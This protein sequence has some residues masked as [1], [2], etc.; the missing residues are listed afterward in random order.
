MAQGDVTTTIIGNLTGPVELRFTPSGAAVAKFSVASTPR[1]L[2]K[3]SGEWKD[4]SP[5]FMPCTAWRD[6]G[7]H[8]AESLDTGTRVILQGRLKQDSWDD[9]ETGA[10]RSRIVMEVDEIGP[11]LRFATAKVEKAARTG[12]RERQAGGFGS[13]PTTTS[14]F[15]G[16]VPF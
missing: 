1:V 15:D 13:G 14:N 12:D 9:K 3:Q 11:S 2:D 5:L 4:G 10:K 8:A 7:E 6:L 16:E